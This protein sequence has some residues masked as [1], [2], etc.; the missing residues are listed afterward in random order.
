V[1]DSCGVVGDIAGLDYI[2][3]PNP[4]DALSS[5]DEVDLIIELCVCV[6]VLT[7]AP[8]REDLLQY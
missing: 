4:A 6:C 5:F 7:W 8:A 3:L 1:H 2:V